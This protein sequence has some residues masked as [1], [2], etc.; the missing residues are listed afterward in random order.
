MKILVNQ[1]DN[2]AERL[3]LM[4]VVGGFNSSNTSQ[5]QLMAEEKGIPSFWVDGPHCIEV[6]SNKIAHRMYSHEM[7]ET[8]NWLP[9]GPIT[10]GITSG[11]STPD[12][13]VEE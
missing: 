2:E 12:S 4:I 10:V 8:S 5:L 13:V 9:E 6:S 11:A 1:Q 3:D 7:L